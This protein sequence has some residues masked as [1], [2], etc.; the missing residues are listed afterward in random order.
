[1]LNFY[2]QF[3]CFCLLG[4][5]ATILFMKKV[6]LDFHLSVCVCVCHVWCARN[7]FDR[8][9]NVFT[10]DACCPWPIH[11]VLRP[12]LNRTEVKWLFVPHAFVLHW[13]D[14]H[15]YR[16]LSVQSMVYRIGQPF[17]PTIANRWQ[18]HSNFVA[19]INRHSGMSLDWVH[20]MFWCIHQRMPSNFPCIW[21]PFYFR[22]SFLRRPVW[23]HSPIYTES[24][25]LLALQKSCPCHRW[26]W[27]VRRWF[28]S[29]IPSILLPALR[30][31]LNWSAMKEQ[32]KRIRIDGKTNIL[33]NLT[34]KIYF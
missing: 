4:S 17:G 1:M 29:P 2:I 21:M 14:V 12:C 25:R 16:L 33:L 9:C 19:P 34:E 3:K 6:S 24:H 11:F 20:W 27:S 13:I 30:C 32:K 8:L 28:L 18:R 15:S 10:C 7:D 23:W 5:F 26:Y 31:T 22:W